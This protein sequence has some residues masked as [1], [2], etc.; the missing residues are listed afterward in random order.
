MT[1]APIKGADS[2]DM[3]EWQRSCRNW[4]EHSTPQHDGYGKLYEAREASRRARIL[5]VEPARTRGPD[6]PGLP[7]AICALAVRF[8][9]EEKSR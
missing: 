2:S 4:L 5:A 7:F 3:N 9:P 6:T 1:R 8:G